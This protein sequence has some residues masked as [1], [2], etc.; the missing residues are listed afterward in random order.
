MAS[1]P[2]PNVSIG[3]SNDTFQALQ[4]SVEMA[5]SNFDAILKSSRLRKEVIEALLCTALFGES[6]IYEELFDPDTKPL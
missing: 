4:W 3:F 5:I 1:D 2:I 6:H